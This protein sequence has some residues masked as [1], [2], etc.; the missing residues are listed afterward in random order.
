MSVNTPSKTKEQPSNDAKLKAKLGILDGQV[1]EPT[2]KATNSVPTTEVGKLKHSAKE[3]IA[4]VNKKH[5]TNISFSCFIK[6]GKDDKGE[7]LWKVATKKGNW[8][9]TTRKDGLFEV[10]RTIYY[11]ESFTIADSNELDQ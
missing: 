7:Q 5:G 10:T 2:R 4:E 8:V 3:A 9:I 1:V 6:N 11:S